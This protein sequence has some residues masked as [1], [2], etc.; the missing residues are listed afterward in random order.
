VY[1]PEDLSCLWESNKGNDEGFLAGRAM[2]AFRL[3]A[4]L[5][6]YATGMEPPRPRLT[7]T[8]LVNTKNDRRTVPRGFL[9]AAQLK[10]AGDWQPA[11]RAMRNLLAH[12]HKLAGLDVALKTEALPVYHESLPDFRFL[13]LHGR[14]D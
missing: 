2:L 8:E 10:H 1:S 13:Y 12:L 7:E 5:V 6:A 11:P 9:K 14:G 3:G 4:N